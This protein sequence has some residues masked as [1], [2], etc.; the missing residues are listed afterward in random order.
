M[1][2]FYSDQIVSWVSSLNPWMILFVTALL[3]PVYVLFIWSMTK[4]YGPK[5]FITSF[6]ISTIGDVVS[7]PHVLSTAGT[8]NP[9]SINLTSDLSIYPLIPEFLK[10]TITLPIINMTVSLGTLMLYVV[11]PIA[12]LILSLMFIHGRSAKDIVSKSLG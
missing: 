10:S 1:F 7:L 3:N 4:E 12:V 9:Q 6:A 8:V 11:V 5:G 2:Y